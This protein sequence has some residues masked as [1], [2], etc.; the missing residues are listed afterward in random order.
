MSSR[1]PISKMFV[2]ML[3]TLS[4]SACAAGKINT[5]IFR[6]STEEN[7]RVIVEAAAYKDIPATRV[8]Y[9]DPRIME[10]YVLYRSR[11]GQAE[12][13]FTETMPMY[14]HNTSLDFDK[15]IATSARLWRFNQGQTLAFDESF[16]LDNN[17]A[18]FWVQTYRQ[19][20]TGRQCAGFST[21]WDKRVDDPEYRPSKILFG[22]HC[23]PKGLAFTADDAAA[24]VKSIEIRGI[25][26][27]LRIN[28]AYDLKKPA[29]PPPPHETQLANLVLAQDGGGGGVAGMPEFPLLIAVTYKSLDGPCMGC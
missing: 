4:L 14:A 18:N 15:L 19:V 28:S 25:S 12:L 26:V 27:P 23:A 22:Y 7:A 3:T 10:E 9:T 17:F 24:F 13:F 20:E 2:L 5:G 11:Q 16:N 1:H 29:P 8:T 21:R 6:Q